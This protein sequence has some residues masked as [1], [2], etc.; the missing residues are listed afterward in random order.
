MTA[1]PALLDRI[2]EATGPDRAID[3]EIDYQLWHQIQALHNPDGAPHFTSSIDA[4]LGLVEKVLPRCRWALKINSTGTGSA[5][6]GNA[7]YPG[8][9]LSG[10]SACGGATPA[11]ALLAAL[12]QPKISESE[13]PKL[14]EVER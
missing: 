8:D 4:A 10:P 7:P 3:R 6:I 9:E 1:L 2:T 13:S 5:Y 14:S 11:L 12:L